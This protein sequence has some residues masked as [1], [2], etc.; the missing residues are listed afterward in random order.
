MTSE[1]SLAAHQHTYDLNSSLGSSARSF[2][3]T[4][5]RLLIC[6]ADNG[7]F[8][9]NHSPAF[10]DKKPPSRLRNSWSAREKIERDTPSWEDDREGPQSYPLAAVSSAWRFWIQASCRCI[11]RRFA[12]SFIA[13]TRSVLGAP[14]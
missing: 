7:S 2:P 9:T 14:A 5:A 6:Q 12:A 3:L 1:R 13:M 11:S 4:A 10:K 8:Y